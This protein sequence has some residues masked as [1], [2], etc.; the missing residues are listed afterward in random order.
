[1]SDVENHL[2]QSIICDNL[3][4]KFLR[5]LQLWNRATL[6]QSQ[7]SIPNCQFHPSPRAVHAHAIACLEAHGGVAG[8]D[9]GR[10]AQFAGDDGRVRE[11]YIIFST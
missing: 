1:M 5:T 9:D 11:G 6:Q 7:F 8:T 3:R 2:R 4:F 10:D